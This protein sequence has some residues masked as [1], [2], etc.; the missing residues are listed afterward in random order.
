MMT[1]WAQ[2]IRHPWF[3]PPT[4]KR[5][6]CTNDDDDDAPFSSD[7]SPAAFSTSRRKRVR[8]TSLERTLA[9]MT[10]ANP[11]EDVDMWP[12]ITPSRPCGLNVILPSS[13][14]EPGAHASEPDD[15]EVEPTL[16]TSS[17]KPP[18]PHGW[19]SISSGQ[20]DIKEVQISSAVLDCLRRRPAAPI[21]LSSQTTQALVLYRALRPPTPKAACDGASRTSIL[22]ADDVMEVE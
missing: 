18:P 3:D 21:P 13:V 1:T 11:S 12:K 17:T 19:E 16:V 10:L 9:H 7:V 8:Y 20:L 14:E 5:K 2:P 6:L 22:V 15:M 4:M